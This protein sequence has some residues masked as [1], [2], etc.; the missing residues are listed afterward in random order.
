V[1]GADPLRRLAAVDDHGVPDDERGGVRHSQTTAGAISSG[2]P[3]R[4]IGSCAITAGRPSG[5]VPPLKRCIIS[6]SMM[7]GQMAL[8]AGAS[9][10]N[11]SAAARPM[12][13][14]APVTQRDLAREAALLVPRA[15]HLLPS[16]L[17]P[18]HGRRRTLIASRWSIAW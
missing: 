13:L 12:P 9:R 11:A 6:V 8:I 5:G 15:H 10:A 7:P 18:G 1:S 4:P 16:A 17:A 2:V 3:I 14:A